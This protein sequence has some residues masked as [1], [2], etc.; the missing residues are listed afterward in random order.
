MQVKSSSEFIVCQVMPQKYRNQLL[1]NK[2]LDALESARMQDRWEW[3]RVTSYTGTIFEPQSPLDRSAA[4]GTQLLHVII[5]YAI[6][7][8]GEIGPL[9]TVKAGTAS[10]KV[11]FA[12]DTSRVTHHMF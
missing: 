12:L 11:H 1:H 9:V 2:M 3:I 5:A 6:L 10:A 7:V 4:D 8:T